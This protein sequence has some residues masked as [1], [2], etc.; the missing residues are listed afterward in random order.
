MLTETHY[1][2]A[3]LLLKTAG[4]Y[5]TAYKVSYTEDPLK[6]ESLVFIGDRVLNMAIA[7][8]LSDRMNILQASRLMGTAVSNS[9]YALRAVELFPELKNLRKP[10]EIFEIAAGAIHEGSECL[11]LSDLRLLANLALEGLVV[12]HDV[13]AD[14]SFQRMLA[15]K[16]EDQEKREVFV[17][18]KGNC[19]EH[20]SQRFR[21]TPRVETLFTG[22]V[23]PYS[24]PTFTASV[25]VDVIDDDWEVSGTG[26]TK[27]DAEQRAFEVLY[28][29]LKRPLGSS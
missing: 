13:S 4:C 23:H 12:D 16:K 9:R 3:N 29:I 22:H 25:T 1:E 20:L 5:N 27:K 17:N 19:L 8:A 15:E 18:W 10:G 26:L 11:D 7:S 2:Y 24:A 28:Q 14:L 6:Q 21:I